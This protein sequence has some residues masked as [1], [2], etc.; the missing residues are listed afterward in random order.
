MFESGTL[1]GSDFLIGKMKQTCF[2]QGF[3][4][5]VSK[6]REQND[7]TLRSVNATLKTVDSFDPKR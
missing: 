3:S 1:C 7:S 4:K 5:A 6:T 2:F